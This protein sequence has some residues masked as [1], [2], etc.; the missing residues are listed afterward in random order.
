MIPMNSFINQNK[1]L[2]RQTFE[3][4]MVNPPNTSQ[5]DPASVSPN[6]LL[7]SFKTIFSFLETHFSSM[8][9]RYFSNPDNSDEILQLFNRLE[10]LLSSVKTF[11]R[12]LPRSSSSPNS[13]SVLSNE[14]SSLATADGND[15]TI[16]TPTLQP[17][18][19]SN[20]LEKE[21]PKELATLGQAPSL[22][23]SSASSLA[24]RVSTFAKF[25]ETLFNMDERIATNMTID[26]LNE[27][28][29]ESKLL[30]IVILLIEN[31]PKTF[32]MNAWA[33][34]LEET[35]TNSPV[36]TNI[37][38][39]SNN[40]SNNNNNSNSN[41][42][43][44]KPHFHIS[45]II[46]RFFGT[47]SSTDNQVSSLKVDRLDF[48]ERQ[49]QRMDKQQA[50]RLSN[51]ILQ[52]CDQNKT[53][54]ALIECV[55]RVRNSKR[56]VFAFLLTLAI[57]NNDI[58]QG[59]QRIEQYLTN[60]RPNESS[61]TRRGSDGR[62][63]T[64]IS[65]IGH[66]SSPALPTIHTMYSNVGE[67]LPPK[68][69]LYSTIEELQQRIEHS[70]KLRE[71]AI[72]RNDEQESAFFQKEI[73]NLEKEVQSL[74]QATPRT[75]STTSSK[76]QL[77]PV[78]HSPSSFN[79]LASFRRMSF[80]NKKKTQH[81][82]ISLHPALSGDDFR[83]SFLSRTT[84]SKSIEAFPDVRGS[85]FFCTSCKRSLDGEGYVLLEGHWY[86]RKCAYSKS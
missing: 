3:N 68:T 20:S 82:S 7:E 36:H 14:N 31:D 72:A 81:R 28:D 50:Q 67:G 52:T 5:L 76:S 41:N 78:S 35:T 59:M 60:I 11:Q 17:V 29:R 45:E 64:P 22:N 54:K 24:A 47:S 86:C 21:S 79:P 25:K 73:E 66:S 40:D 61:G 44:L 49:I 75:R 34:D 4:I 12:N 71:D 23:L 33:F 57:T 1:E 56:F 32:V 27:F 10:V 70:K 74:Q 42:S 77:Q 46:E 48:L 80:S 85:G 6:E 26:L 37:S 13:V 38:S 18:V 58:I 2:L 53:L 16:R 39:S 69:I 30:P 63:V 84:S 15:S 65:P 8:Q 9:K 43:N 55:F 19:K 62:T 51:S 83:D